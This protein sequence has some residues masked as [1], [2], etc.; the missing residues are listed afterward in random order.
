MC[1]S[2]AGTVRVERESGQAER[3][4]LVVDTDV[5]GRGLDPQLTAVLQWIA[6][7]IADLPLMQLSQCS[8]PELQ[9]VRIR[10]DHTIT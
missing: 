5:W 9:Q 1:F 2:Y 6:V 8:A 10:I 7:S 3:A 4:L